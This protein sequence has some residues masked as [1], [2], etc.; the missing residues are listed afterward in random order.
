MLSYAQ[1]HMED[2]QGPQAPLREAQVGG[3]EMEEAM[4]R[5]WTMLLMMAL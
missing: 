3:G 1:C 4:A 5:S 2:T